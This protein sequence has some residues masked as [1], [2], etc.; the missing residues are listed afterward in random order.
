MSTEHSD[1]GVWTQVPITAGCIVN[2]T[3]VGFTQ[4]MLFLRYVSIDELITQNLLHINKYNA[5]SYLFDHT[6]LN[7]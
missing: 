7:L 6:M 2:L 4:P 3:H 5:Y 1:S